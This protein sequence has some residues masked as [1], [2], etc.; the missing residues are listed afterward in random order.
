[1]HCCKPDYVTKNHI[2]TPLYALA[3][4]LLTY[5]GAYFIISHEKIIIYR[6]RDVSLI[7]RRIKKWLRERIGRT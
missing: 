7:K 5:G 2:C 4:T 6:T 1:M 3:T